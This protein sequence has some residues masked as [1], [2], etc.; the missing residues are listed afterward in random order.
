MLLAAIVI[1]ALKESSGKISSAQD[2]VL[3][4]LG[5]HKLV[6][7]WHNIP[8]FAIEIDPSAIPQLESD[9]LVRRV[10]ID[11]GGSGSL[12]QSVPLIGGD[13]V[14]A[15]GYLFVLTPVLLGTMVLLLVALLVVNVSPEESRHYPA[16]WW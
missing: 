2:A 7:R 16:S 13:K 11:T 3:S 9:P 12:A 6:A 8:G 4:R 14:H 10:D 15:L 5:T 1:V